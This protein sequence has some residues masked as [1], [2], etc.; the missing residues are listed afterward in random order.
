MRSMVFDFDDGDFGGNDD[1][2]PFV[3]CTPHKSVCNH[4]V[5]SLLWRPIHCWSMFAMV[6][7]AAPVNSSIFS[8]LKDK[9]CHCMWNK[10][11]KKNYKSF[12]EKD[13]GRIRNVALCYYKPNCEK[14]SHSCLQRAHTRTH[15]HKQDLGVIT[16]KWLAQ[17]R[18]KL[19][20]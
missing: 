4:I 6:A 2:W 1:K 3:C 12:H 9:P 14:P 5:S 19:G 13:V 15:T 10:T 17:G 16:S 7:I 18:L 11:N 8:N 20:I